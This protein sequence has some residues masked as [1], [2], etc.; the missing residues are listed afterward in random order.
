M[1]E[2]SLNG[3]ITG[4]VVI[5]TLFTAGFPPIVAINAEK[6]GFEQAQKAVDIQLYDEIPVWEIGDSWMYYAEFSFGM[7]EDDATDISIYL[8]F[9]D[10]SFTIEDD[11]GDS[12]QTALE[13]N[14]E[15]DFFINFEGLPRVS[16]ILKDVVMG[17]YAL[18]EKDN[19]GIK[20]LN[21]NVDGKLSLNLVPLPLDIEITV[22]F[23]PSYVSL[24][25]P[26]VIGKEWTINE[27]YV[28]IEGFI[29][30]P[31]ITKLF[32]NIPDEIP[33]HEYVHIGGFTAVCTGKKDIRVNAGMYNAYNITFD[34][35]ASFYYSTVAGNIIKFALSSDDSDFFD[36]EFNYE[37]TSTTYT[38]QGAPKKPSKPSGPTKGEPNTEYTYTTSTT[39]S[40][41]DQVYYLYD[42]G[43]GT[44]S[45]WIGPYDSGRAMSTSHTW[46]QKGTYTIRVKAKDPEEHESLWS[47]PL[48]ISMPKNKLLSRFPL[49]FKLLEENPCLFPILRQFLS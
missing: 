4:T 15:G 49:F 19:L 16:G 43:D 5:F 8:A 7:H 12:Y 36:F 20:T 18:L 28:S 11:T 14:V 9:N 40:E 48:S 27:S 6:T 25:F 10:L 1:R 42:W 46:T 35:S 17:G 44:Y 13:S 39:D 33:I 23:D 45:E 24:A 3:K 37:L 47:D 30:L 2:I 38:V 26:L 21:I 34:G 29:S 22:I 32:Q 41:G 31:G